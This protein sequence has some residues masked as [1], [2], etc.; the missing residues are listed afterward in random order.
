[1]SAPKKQQHQY[2]RSWKNLLLN[3]RYQLRFTLF[4]VGLSAL[5]MAVLG[6][7]VMREASKATTILKMAAPCPEP[8]A[9]VSGGESSGAATSDEV[10]VPDESAPGAGDEAAEDEAAKDEAAEDEAAEDEAAEDEAAKDEEPSVD[11]P[12]EGAEPA[13]GDQ[14]GEGERPHRQ[15]SVTT[16]EMTIQKQVNPEYFDMLLKSRTCEMKQ[17]A[18]RHRLYAGQRLILYVL[19]AVGLMLIIGLTLYGIKMTHKVAGP[20]YKISLY[21]A[22]MKDGKYDTV[23]NLRKGD[24][25]VEFYDH[26]KGAHAGMRKM[27]EE[28]IA[29]LRA[30]LE[31]AEKEKLA[32]K[33]PELAARLEELRALLDRKEGSLV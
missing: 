30:M 15:V 24:H 25:L 13:A 33:S 5:L 8:P 32:D 1:M 29:A 4:M 23:Y 16:S 10:Q 27:E 31:V 14:A 11:E 7:W 22:K 20:L 19:I 28:D 6:W 26:F 2:K 3:K 18:E 9:L 12:T 17:A 21:F